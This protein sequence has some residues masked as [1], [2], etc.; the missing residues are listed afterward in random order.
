M[1]N[2]IITSLI[3]FLNIASYAQQDPDAKVILDKLSSVTKSHKN[4]QADFNIVY[5]NDKDNINN[6]SNGQIT[7]MG[8][9]YKLNFMG[10]ISFFDGKTQWSYLKDANEVNITEPEPDDEDIFNNPKK[11][12]TIYENDFKYQ[13]ISNMKE[14]GTNYSLVDL[15]P[16]NINEDYSRIRLQ[17]NTDKYYLESAT[18]FG[19]DGSHY[20]IKITKYV[21]DL[22]LDDSFFVFDSKKFPDVEVVDMR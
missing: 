5:Q 19:K 7:M 3:V 22:K 21:T 8:D 20:N 12:F 11:L 10:T 18:I 9:K 13:L 17:I 16:K 14:N 1:K 2:I 6:N 15:Y 4:I